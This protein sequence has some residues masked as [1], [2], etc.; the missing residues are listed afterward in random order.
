[1]TAPLGAVPAKMASSP[2]AKMAMNHTKPV[3]VA[4][5][6]QKAT[7][8]AMKPTTALQPVCTHRH[9]VAP[10]VALLHSRQAK[11]SFSKAKQSEAKQSK[12]KQS[13][14]KQSKAEQS[15][16]KQSKAKQSRAKRSRAKQSKIKTRQDKSSQV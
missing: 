1:M 13:E 5:G 4:G 2:T 14:A 3:L 7:T 9:S 15:K 16:A 8:M 12:A 11:T 10:H 6:S